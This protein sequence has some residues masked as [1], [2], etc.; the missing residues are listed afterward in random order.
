[1]DQNKKKIVVAVVV[2]FLMISSTAGF[3]F[4]GSEDNGNL[5]TKNYK[6][7]EFT[8]LQTG[9]ITNINNQEI[10]LY[11]D[12]EFVSQGKTLIKDEYGL[13]SAEKVYLSINPED[14]LEKIL[15]HFNNVALLIKPRISV[16]C[17]EDSE[18]CKT[19][20]I[21]T[22][23]NASPINKVIVIKE[24]QNLS[25]NYRDNCLEIYGSENEM[26]KFIDKLILSLLPDE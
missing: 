22:C 24:Q 7:H 3:I 6:G 21:R 11:N 16:S 9:W 2:I 1:M 4:S 20:T 25:I 5:I 15:Q 26:I 17:Y 13:N 18:K 10:Y 12:P 19:F 8:S 14:R 23:E